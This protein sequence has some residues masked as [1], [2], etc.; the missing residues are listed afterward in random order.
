MAILVFPVAPVAA[1]EEDGHRVVAQLMIPF[2]KSGAQEE[3]KHL[4][5]DEWQR[6]L[7]LRAATV[8]A[9]LLRP[10][11]AHLKSLQLTLF[12]VDDKAFDPAVN[13]PQNACSVAAILESRLVLMQSNFTKLEKQA[14]LTY[15]MHYMVEMHIPVNCGLVRDQGGQKI[16]LKNS[17]LQ[18]VNLSWIWNYD[19]YRK[20]Q[21]RWF[22]YAQELYRKTD[23]MNVDQWVESVS[24]P[25]WAFETHQV[26]LKKVYP[27]AAQGRYSAELQMIGKKVL[28]QQLVKAAVRTATLLNEMF[29]AKN[30]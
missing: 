2:L 26:A 24:V 21:K 8:E 1:F 13:C 10:Q 14:A 28:E 16:Y 22:T 7:R 19:L 20:Q 18:P 9:D 5:G 12:N 15:L 25:D 27:L 3:L 30:K 23:E 11:N 29:P 17:D 4:L 6:E